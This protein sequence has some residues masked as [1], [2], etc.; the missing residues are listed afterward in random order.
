MPEEHIL[1]VTDWYG[2]D[3]MSTLQCLTVRSA[4]AS[5]LDLL[6][7]FPHHAPNEHVRNDALLSSMLPILTTELLAV[8]RVPNTSCGRS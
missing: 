5:A 8:Q 2:Y 3:I 7:S 6:S 4:S 1:A